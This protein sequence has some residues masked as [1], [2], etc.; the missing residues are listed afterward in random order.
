M[1]DVLSDPILPIFAILAIGYGLGRSG[2]F[3]REDARTLNRFALLIPL[4]A[5]LFSL[6]M[7]TPVE[8]IDFTAVA[9]YAAVEIFVL[10]GVFF[11][12]RAFKRPV[13]E[14]LLIA[15]CAVFVNHFL[16]VLPIAVRLYGDTAA[17]PVTALVILD[18]VIVFGGMLIALEATTQDTFS[19][20]NTLRAIAKNPIILSIC[21]TI[22]LKI[23]AVPIPQGVMTFTDFVGAAA[24]P[25]ALF[26][27]GV[28][29]SKS[30][31]WPP[32]PAVI[33][34]SAIKLLAFPA[35]LMLGLGAV[36]VQDGW[37]PLMI[38]VAAGPSGAMSFSLAMLYKI[39]TD[40]IAPV[41]IW[42][43]VL[44]VF[45]LAYLA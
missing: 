22:T 39:D 36:A 17:L 32:S 10:A 6:V 5:L 42:T 28:V 38:L 33:T 16:Y 2:G 13:P 40:I 25:L 29:L 41:I 21:A 24:A 31:V 7:R 23:L 11:I 26:A 15:L 45:S 12:A 1:F 43:S 44:S 30:P 18:A 4:P 14:S 9:L 8:G 34:F 19:L 3:S 20:M 27:L 37:H 35:I